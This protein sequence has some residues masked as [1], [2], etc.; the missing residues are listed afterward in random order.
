MQECLWISKRLFIYLSINIRLY[1]YNI[2]YRNRVICR[3]SKILGK[4][5]FT[6][7]KE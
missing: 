5:Y 3:V 4:C 7:G 1:I 2:H 6:L